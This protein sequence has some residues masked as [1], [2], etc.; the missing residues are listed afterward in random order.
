MPDPASDRGRR[1]E[2]LETCHNPLS[3]FGLRRCGRHNDVAAPRRCSGIACVAA[4][5]CISHGARNA[6]HQGSSAGPL[7]L[8]KTRRLWTPGGICRRASDPAAAVR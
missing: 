4:P 1:R 5:A 7:G 8:D 2:T 6:T 3:P